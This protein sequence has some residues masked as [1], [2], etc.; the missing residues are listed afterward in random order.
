MSSRS[1]LLLS[2]LLLIS[3]SV[4]YYFFAGIVIKNIFGNTPEIIQTG[5]ILL[6]FIGTNGFVLAI[7]FFLL[8]NEKTA[9]VKKLLLG[10]GILILL[11]LAILTLTQIILFP[12]RTLLILLVISAFAY[13]IQLYFKK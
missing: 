10:G 13:A 5:G 4:F 1:I 12:L 8:K 11:Q 7:I 3:Q 2:S 6:K 9:V